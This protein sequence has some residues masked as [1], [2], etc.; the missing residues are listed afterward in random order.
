VVRSYEDLYKSGRMTERIEQALDRNDLV[1]KVFEQISNRKLPEDWTPVQVM[2]EKQIFHNAHL[3]TWDKANKTIGE[4][5]Y[6]D[7][8]A[9]LN[10]R[11]DWPARWAELGVMV[12][13]F[14]AQEHG[15]AGGSYDTG[16]E[17]ANKVFDI[18]PPIPGVRYG[19]IHML[20][21]TKKMSSSKGNLMTPEQTLDILPAEVLRYFV[22]RSTP[23]RTLYFDSGL[24][25]INLI[26]EFS[27]VQGDAEHEF[28]DAFNFAVSG[29]VAMVISSVPYRQLVDA[30]QATNGSYK[31]VLEALER[32]GA[33]FVNDNDRA[34]VE[35]E[36]KYVKNWIDNYAP[37]SVKF[38]LQTEFHEV[39]LSA[40]QR[41]FLGELAG[42]L[43]DVKEPDGQQVHELIYAAKEAADIKPGAAFQALYRIL[44]AKDSGPK[45]GW[46]L[47]SL[48]QEQLLAR[49]NHFAKGV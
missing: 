15:A 33:K 10:W 21:D 47:A 38:T 49:L 32:S 28:R 8:H 48:D 13:P 42:R 35:F 24:G 27:A 2:N 45:A 12:E 1:R 3:G 46:F 14:S 41:K 6:V 25:I 9:K 5:S 30:Y 37:E 23:D 44:L 11:L 16:V 19:N 34:M 40:E 43:E 17:F 20:G 4:A 36:L 39:E 18:A 7:G 29:K 22:V 26:D 31:A